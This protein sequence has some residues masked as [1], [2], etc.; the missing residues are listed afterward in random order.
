MFHSYRDEWEW[1]EKYHLQYRKAPSRTAFCDAFRDFKVKTVNDTAHYAK[2]VKKSHAQ[3]ELTHM[4]REVADRI[5]TGDVD[6]AIAMVQQSVIDISTSLGAVYDGD[7]FT[8]NTD[9]NA[10]LL[11][12]RERHQAGGAAGIATG[13]PTL[14]ERTGG[15]QPGELWI[16]GARLGE[17]KSYMMQ[18]MAVEAVVT[19]KR[20]Q[21]DALEQTRAQVSM[22]IYSMLSGRMSDQ[23][24][25][26]SATDLMRGRNY[27][28]RHFYKFMNRV[29]RLDG[30]LFVA[31]AARGR[32]SATTITSQIERNKPDIVFV[33]Y[34]TLMA[35]AT[36]DWQGVAQ[37]STDLLQLGNMYSIPIVAA[38]QLNRT[39]GVVSAKGEPPGAEA[40][41]QS[42]AIGQDATAVIT[43]K[44]ISDSVVMMR[45]AKNRNGPAGFS[46]YCHFDPQSGIFN[47]VTH[48]RAMELKDLDDDR[49]DM[50]MG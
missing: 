2:Q 44:K 43:M 50:L 46:W 42:D 23:S 45:L 18:R 41:S 27:D 3:H 30:K 14:D 12:R 21:F 38:S 9:I 33:D 37:L 8:S 32:V 26:F 16:I 22:R 4:V 7:I 6:N 28:P 39:S 47:E 20:V 13:F 1:I 10:E 31:D 35:K 5:S 11:L 19:G 49:R 48:S 29:K 36:N 25:V 15:P 24:Q 34:I 17:G 40:L